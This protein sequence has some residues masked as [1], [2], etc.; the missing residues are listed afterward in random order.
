MSFPNKR[1]EPTAW[2]PTR[3]RTSTCQP[4]TEFASEW[5]DR[6]GNCRLPDGAVW[7]GVCTFKNLQV[8]ITSHTK[9]PAN[10]GRILITKFDTHYFGPYDNHDKYYTLSGRSAPQVDSSATQAARFYSV[11]ASILSTDIRQTPSPMSIS[12]VM[13]TSCSTP[14]TVP[15]AVF[16]RISAAE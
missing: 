15:S 16:S 5:R 4:Y 12:P 2:Q 1:L 8:V 14:M 10:A 3:A 11:R 13:R 9:N 6:R 7:S